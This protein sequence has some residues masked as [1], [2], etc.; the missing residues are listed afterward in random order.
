MSRGIIGAGNWIVDKVK[1]ISRWPGEG[2]LCN[3]LS[4]E[5]GWGGGPCNVL[6]DLAALGTDIPLYAAGVLGKDV[7]GEQLLQ[8]IRNRNIDDRYMTFSDSASTSFTDVMTDQSSGR[9][10]FFHN[11]GANAELGYS[12]ME[13]IDVPAKIFYLG[14]LLLLDA[15]DCPDPEYG[16]V[17]ARVLSEM[18]S[19]G[20]MTVVDVVTED[21]ARFHDTVLPALSQVDC[22]VVNEVE[23]GHCCGIEVR[24]QDGSINAEALISSVKFLMEQGVRELVVV[25][26]P[27]GAI[28]VEKGG[29]THAVPS[30]YIKPDEIV[31][32][33]GAGDAF[34]AGVL[35][36]L[37]E[38]LPI[39]D[40]LKL[41][42]AGA[43]FNLQS[44]TASGGAPTQ[45][46][47]KA[48][49]GNCPFGNMEWYDL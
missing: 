15:M 6:F 33:V 20:Y 13:P 42:G 7:E 11:R 31:G 26:F 18:K 44:A 10:T 41:A 35:Y 19:R 38:D 14:Y 27:E 21:A 29:D 39:D 9:R 12:H 28:A 25:H 16:T 30:C 32:S 8:Q 3:I 4:Q 17:A 45:Q 5:S 24:K 2:E 1:M 34:C 23:A 43:W 49:L 36:G 22:L 37:H 48:H 40:S 47:I 46:Q